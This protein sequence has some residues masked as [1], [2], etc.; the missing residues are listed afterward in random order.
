MAEID[1][2]EEQGALEHR[3]RSAQRTARTSQK[4]GVGGNPVLKEA[5]LRGDYQY[6]AYQLR[7]GGNPRGWRKKDIAAALPIMDRLAL[8]S[9]APE[10]F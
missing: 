10:A 9:H 8:G 1:M 7:Y 6:F 2:A 3:E 5:H 4:P